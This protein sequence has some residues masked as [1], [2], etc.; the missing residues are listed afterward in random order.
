MQPNIWATKTTVN[1]NLKMVKI[2]NKYLLVKTISLTLLII[3]NKV[4]NFIKTNK[5][6]ALNS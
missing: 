4:G 6:H 1:I 3:V 5:F 2:F